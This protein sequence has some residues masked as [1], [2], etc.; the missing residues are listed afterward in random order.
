MESREV[1][2][3]RPTEERGKRTSDSKGQEGRPVRGP[4]LGQVFCF[5]PYKSGECTRNLTVTEVRR[6]L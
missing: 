2:G 5:L 3:F 4:S 6:L 1:E